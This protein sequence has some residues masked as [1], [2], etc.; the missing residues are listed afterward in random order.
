MIAH[1]KVAQANSIS[2]VISLFSGV[3]LVKSS[4]LSM[5]SDL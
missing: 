4:I 3:S 5:Y 1:S 2:D